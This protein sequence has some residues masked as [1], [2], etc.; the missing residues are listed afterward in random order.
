M[1]T[2]VVQ[3]VVPASSTGMPEV[4]LELVPEVVLKVQPEVGPEVRKSPPKVVLEM[5]TGSHNRKSNRKSGQK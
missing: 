4:Q 3:E 2:E 1:H 5:M